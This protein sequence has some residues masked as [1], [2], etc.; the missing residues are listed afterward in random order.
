MS[1]QSVFEKIR[2]VLDEVNIPYFVSGSFASSAHGI[3]RATHDIDVVIAP[4]PVQLKQLLERFP[5]SEYATSEEDALDALARETSFQIIDY[6]TMWRV[7]FLIGRSDEFDR[8]RFARRSVVEIAGVPLYT[9]TAE[10]ILITKL[11]WAKLGESE[12]QLRDAAGIIEV[13]GDRLDF[14]YIGKWVGTL[15]LE[16]Q[17]LAARRLAG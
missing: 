6:A 12:R 17:W 1:V 16:G 8:S 9:T 4:S 7:D 15:E 3:P 13:Q 5:P 14:Q 10:D 2:A 11:W